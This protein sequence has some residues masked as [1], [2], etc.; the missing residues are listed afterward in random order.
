MRRKLLI[1]DSGSEGRKDIAKGHAK[2]LYQDNYSAIWRKLDEDKS[3]IKS[4]KEF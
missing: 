1:H 3:K 4:Q 2:K